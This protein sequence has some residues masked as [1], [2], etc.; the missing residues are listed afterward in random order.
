MDEINRKSVTVFPGLLK[1]ENMTIIIC[2]WLFCLTTLNAYYV[3]GYVRSYMS[4]HFPY[5][6]LFMKL[7]LWVYPVLAV[8]LMIIVIKNIFRMSGKPRWDLYI[9]DY[10]IAVAV[11]LP[12]YFIYM[13]VLAQLFDMNLMHRFFGV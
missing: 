5:E 8:I 4:K 6:S 9:L 10:F 3:L 11:S 2:L 1:K 12:V 7:G 13:I